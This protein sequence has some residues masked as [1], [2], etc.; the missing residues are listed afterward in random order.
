[1]WVLSK[2]KTGKVSKAAIRYAGHYL[3]DA[4]DERVFVLTGFRKNGNIHN[5]TF[6]SF[7]AARKVG[8]VKV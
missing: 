1:M 7:A 3:R 8:W 4:K 6:E 5:V 2:S